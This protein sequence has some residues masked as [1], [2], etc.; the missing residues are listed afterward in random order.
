MRLVLGV[1][2]TKTLPQTGAVFSTAAAVSDPA[3]VL[4]KL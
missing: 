2:R 1:K 3:S 4:T